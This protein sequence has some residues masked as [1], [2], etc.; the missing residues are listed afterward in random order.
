MK[1]KV[2]PGVA[3]AF[4]TKEGAEELDIKKG[5]HVEALIKT[6]EVTVAKP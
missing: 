1:I 3:T 5:D 2:K 4:I 6:T